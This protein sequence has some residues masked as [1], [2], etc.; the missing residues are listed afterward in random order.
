MK[1]FRIDKLAGEEPQLPIHMFYK[2]Q[3]NNIEP[4]HR[5]DFIEIVYIRDG[6]AKETVN[7]ETYD[8][9]RG[10]LIFINLGST[11]KFIPSEG[12]LTYY[13]ICLRPEVVG[14]RLITPE[15]AF[16]VLQLTAFDEFRKE[17]DAGKTFFTGEERKK[18]ETL[19]REMWLEYNLKR[20]SWMPVVESYMNVLMVFLLRRFGSGMERLPDR[21][22]WEELS[23]Y[24]DANLGNDLTLSALA[25]K[26]FYNPSYFSR[27]FKEKFGTSLTDYVNRRR[28]D[29]ACALLAD[30][31]LSVEAVGRQAGFASKTSF[32]R[33]FDAVT[34]E[35]PS[36]YRK[37]LFTK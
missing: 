9:H 24:I 14:E 33:V 22:V 12:G 11:H 23:R 25:G 15:N 8:V 36:D 32:Y 4:I 35:R 18:V 17:D 37:K 10:D 21:T 1:T 3:Q 5:H 7:T 2:Q 34:G 28:V 6:S 20:P 30:E 29:L 16:S 26:C 31:S 13:N 19:L 27:A